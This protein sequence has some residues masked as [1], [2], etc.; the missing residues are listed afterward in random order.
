[1]L[2]KTKL[3]FIPRLLGILLSLF[4]IIFAFSNLSLD[5][6]WW[7][8]ISGFVVRLAPSIITLGL[9]FLAHFFAIFGGFM[10][11][12]IGISYIYQVGLDRPLS[13]YLVIP[14]PF[15]IIGTLFIVERFMQASVEFVDVVHKD[16]TLAGQMRTKK[17]VHSQGLWHRTVYVW[18]YN[19]AGNILLQKRSELDERHAGAWDV[20]VA[21]HVKSGETY[22]QAAV[23]EIKEE[24]GLKIKIK[25]LQPTKSFSRVKERPKDKYFNKELVQEYIL[26]C[27]HVDFKIRKRE[28][29]KV[30]F[31]SSA[32][33]EEMLRDKNKIFVQ[34]GEN[35][36]QTVL[37]L[38][39]NNK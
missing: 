27:D 29:Q 24:I 18:I 7:K 10:Y 9:L 38:I 26:K 14:I 15:F 28:V 21:G 39:K 23:R 31:V 2:I 32:Q 25:Q 5:E 36:Y 22:E 19:S 12:M 3:Y 13:W 33:L 8:L 11:V 37:E 30:E 17:T 1:M 6:G 34:H 20:S 16:G 35:Y 4:L